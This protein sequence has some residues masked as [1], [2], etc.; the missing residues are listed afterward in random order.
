M[1]AV[2][3]KSSEDPRLDRNDKR[4]L[5]I[6]N[7]IRKGEL[8]TC[9]KTFFRNSFKT[10]IIV[11]QLMTRI[12][13]S[14]LPQKDHG[15]TSMI[16]TSCLRQF[17]LIPILNISSSTCSNELPYKKTSFNFMG[18]NFVSY[19]C[20][21]FI[22]KTRCSQISDSISRNTKCLARSWT[23]LCPKNTTANE[24]FSSFSSSANRVLIQQPPDIYH[25]FFNSLSQSNLFNSSRI[26]NPLLFGIDVIALS[27]SEVVSF[28]WL[29]E[30]IENYGGLKNRIFGDYLYATM[31]FH[32]L[33][34]LDTKFCS[35]ISNVA[36]KTL[37]EANL[38]LS[39]SEM[40]FRNY[41]ESLAVG[42]CCSENCKIYLEEREKSIHQTN[43]MELKSA[44]FSS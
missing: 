38:G 37:L 44:I 6:A 7:L 8:S 28:D 29:A 15:K 33:I 39:S 42:A 40:R 22:S 12:E 41:L 34:T 3:G 9:F 27:K 32:Y 20:P 13:E 4:I 18:N 11:D 35:W 26:S 2:P 25:E 19:F 31:G 30:F 23:K 1:G 43:Q 14:C 5:Q 36:S 16:L 21:L 24:F 10:P 17:P